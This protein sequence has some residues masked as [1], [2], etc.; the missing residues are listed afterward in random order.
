[1]LRGQNKETDQGLER[2]SSGVAPVVRGPAK[3]DLQL[4]L[5]NKHPAFA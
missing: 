1:M 3:Y 4:C 5:H 2:T